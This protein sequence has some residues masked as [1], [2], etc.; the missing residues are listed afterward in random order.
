MVGACTTAEH[1]WLIAGRQSSTAGLRLKPGPQLPGQPAALGA[2]D[3]LQ[4]RH[5]IVADAAKSPP[6]AAA[7]ARKRDADGATNSAA[8]TLDAIP[9]ACI[10]A[11]AAEPTS[12]DSARPAAAT[13]EAAAARRPRASAV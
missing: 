2:E 5:A 4:L 10:G 11:R 3:G 6:N 1:H 12:A 13:L 8:M 9:R 7:P